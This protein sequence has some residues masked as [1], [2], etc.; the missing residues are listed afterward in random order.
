MF[1]WKC[2]TF[3]LFCVILFCWTIEN[4]DATT[5]CNDFKSCEDDTISDD[6][7]WCR[8][9]FAC[10]DA[11]IDVSEYA[12]CGGQR[13]CQ[14]ASITTDTG[15]IYCDGWMGCLSSQIDVTGDGGVECRGRRGCESNSINASSITVSC[16]GEE[17]C[18]YTNINSA[19]GLECNGF[20]ACKYAIVSDTASIT[21]NGDYGMKNALISSSNVDTLVINS[22]GYYGLSGAQLDCYDGS[23]CTV[24]CGEGFA[25]KGFDFYC[26]DGASCAVNCDSDC[27][28]C[29][30][31]TTVTSSTILKGK[32]K[33]QEYIKPEEDLGDNLDADDV[34]G[35]SHRLRDEFELGKL[36]HVEYK[37]LLEKFN[38]NSISTMILFVVYIICIYKI[39]EICLIKGYQKCQ[40]KYVETSDNMEYQPLVSYNY[41]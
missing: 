1:A 9:W 26:Y 15:S 24:N 39:I 7:V 38:I 34:D 31:I 2:F 28:D 12:I 6:S 25:C 30:S 14:N 8:G 19:S 36:N 22:N 13:G 35:E 5:L 3:V 23:N 29:P 16:E 10:Y 27:S 40:N 4:C 18:L 32:E 20:Y 17:S 33:Y 21:S 37:R 11:T 41:L